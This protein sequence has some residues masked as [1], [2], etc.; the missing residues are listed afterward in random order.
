MSNL[1]EDY[2]QKSFL[3]SLAS[4]GTSVIRIAAQVNHCSPR[5]F[6]EPFECKLVLTLNSLTYI[7]VAKDLKSNRKGSWNLP[8]LHNNNKLINNY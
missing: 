4:V 8:G 1:Q 3:L 5:R 7:H 6:A 2:K